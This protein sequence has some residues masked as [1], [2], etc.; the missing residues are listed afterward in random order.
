MKFVYPVNIGNN[1]KK[2]AKHLKGASNSAGY[3]PIGRLNTWH[4]GIHFEGEQPI[5]AI[6]DGIIIAYR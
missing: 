6:A 3:Y 5:Y 4:G 1:I 2:D